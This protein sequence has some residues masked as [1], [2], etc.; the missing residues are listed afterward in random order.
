MK[1]YC[2]N[3]GH[4]YQ[5][6]DEDLGMGYADPRYNYEVCRCPENKVDTYLES[7]F[8]DCAVINKNNDCKHFIVRTPIMKKASLFTR[9]FYDFTV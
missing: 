7:K 8:G 9:L 4:H 2:A 1:V 6:K 3:C 5:Y